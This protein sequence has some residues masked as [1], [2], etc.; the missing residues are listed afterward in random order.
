MDLSDADLQCRPET[1][2]REVDPPIQVEMAILARAS[3]RSRYLIMT[4]DFLEAFSPNLLIAAV[5]IFIAWVLV[6]FKR[7]E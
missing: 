2:R 5:L 3:T 6:R 7:S 4:G 1:D